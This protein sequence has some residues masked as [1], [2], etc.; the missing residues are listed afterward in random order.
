MLATMAFGT[1]GVGTGPLQIHGTCGDSTLPGQTFTVETLSKTGEG[2]ASLT[3][4]GG[5]EWSFEMQVASSRA[6]FNLA[7]VN[8]LETT[9]FL[10]GVG[11]LSSPAD[12]IAVADAKGVWQTSLMG[13]Q[14]VDCGGVPTDATASA[15]GTLT[16]NTVGVGTVDVTS[17]STC[18]DGE[19][20]GNTVTIVGLNADGSGTAHMACAV[21]GCGFDLS[22]Q[23]SPDRSIMNL[24]TVSPGDPGD[25]LAGVAI[26]RSTAGNITKT[27]LAGPWQGTLGNEDVHSDVGAA[28]LTFKLNAKALTKGLTITVHDTEGD[29]TFDDVPF[30]VET[31]NPDGS[32][33]ACLSFEAVCDFPLKIQVSPDRS[34][35][36]VVVVE[37]GHDDFLA[38]LLIHQRRLGTVGFQIVD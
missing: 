36:S 23:M 35:I 4:G 2:T 8:P 13:H 10:D 37:P 25:F 3:C 1:N 26:R 5:C 11:V 32:G 22:F 18:G 30:S 9:H 31:L 17:H 24:V 20:L 33:T 6:L 16:L 27:N 29:G 34:V 14:L 19:S 12:H 38:G 7:D 21:G 15:V 28:V